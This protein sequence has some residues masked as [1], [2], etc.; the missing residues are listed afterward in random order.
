MAY[1]FSLTTRKDLHVQS[2]TN[3]PVWTTLAVLHSL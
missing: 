2:L 3:I 1:D